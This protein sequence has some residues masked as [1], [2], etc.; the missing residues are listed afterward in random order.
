MLANFA[1]EQA[2]RKSNVRSRSPVVRDRSISDTVKP[3]QPGP[4][5]PRRSAKPVRSGPV[6]NGASKIG[7]SGLPRAERPL[8]VNLLGKENVV[9]LTK[10]LALSTTPTNIS[11]DTDDTLE[12]GRSEES[13]I[14]EA[15]TTKTPKPPGVQANEPIEYDDGKST[16]VTPEML[17]ECVRKEGNHDDLARL[18]AADLSGKNINFITRLNKCSMLRKLD[19]SYNRIKWMRGLD[20]LY[21]LRELRLTCNK[22]TSISEINKLTALEH[23]HLQINRISE[24]GKT[25]LR[26]NKKLRTLRLDGNELKKLQHLDGQGMLQHFD[27]SQ[28]H[29]TKIEGLGMMGQ[30]EVLALA[31]N[32]IQTIEGLGAMV[33][34]IL[35]LSLLALPVQKHKY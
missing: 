9:L 24:I 12:S 16:E 28:N 22:V 11:E 7:R 31:F 1:G 17:T 35:L 26:D 20:N 25:A 3:S 6:L 4:E 14:R 33:H 30:L 13:S 23:L 21:Q 19:L 2:R 5:S 15:F 27:A 34:D 29:L 32:Q 18:L 8:S 10:T